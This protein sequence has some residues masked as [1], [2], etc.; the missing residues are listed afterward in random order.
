MECSFSKTYLNLLHF[1]YFLIGVSILGI[2][3]YLIVTGNKYA[4]D[5]SSW[6][7][8]VPFVCAFVLIFLGLLG[9]CCAKEGN[10]CILSIY[11]VISWILGVANIFAGSFVLVAV[12]KWLK[13]ISE[14]PNASFGLTGSVGGVQIDLSDFLL[15]L[16]DG[17]CT[18]T[19]TIPQCIGTPTT[20]CFVQP[21]FY[22]SG[23]D[24]G[25]ENG[26]VCTA[27][28]LSSSC[29]DTSTFLNA[30]YQLSED[31]LLGAGITLVVFGTVLFLAGFASCR[32][33][34]KGSSKRKQP[35][36]TDRSA[37][38]VTY[39]NQQGMTLA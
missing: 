19:N 37:G 9:C 31:T 23:Y 10:W 32:L 3:I 8:W 14:T 26:D 22:D 15:G 1:I 7:A 16:Y 13:N 2:S 27:S 12:L 24:V 33:G 28:D 17:C 21:S 29:A 39:G 35:R 30:F 6:Y 20:Y 11:A 4:P 18:K 25:N 34:C 5:V 38:T 36:H